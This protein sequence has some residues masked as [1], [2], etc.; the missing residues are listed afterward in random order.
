MS[1]PEVT[2]VSFG[3]G[4]VG[5]VVN[6]LR[7]LGVTARPSDDPDE[8]R[9]APRLILPGVGSFDA[10]AQRLR[11]LGLVE[12][13][14]EAVMDRGCP[15]L[16]ICL[17]MQLFAESSAEG[18]EPGLGWLAGR[19]ERIDALGD[20]RPPRVPHMGWNTLDL[21]HEKGW[22]LAGLD[23]DARFYFAHSYSL[24]C[25]D[26]GDVLT[27]TTYGCE[28]TSAVHRGNVT[29]TQFHPEKS[30]RYGMRLLENFLA[31]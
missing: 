28:F 11:R 13:L 21:H 10:A 4:N 29:G 17:G 26:P 18:C 1:P 19:V 2:I 12:A 20:D 27:T 3:A 31:R 8:V 7:R 9:S 24:V 23:G 15:I 14:K 5:S 6:M 30:H 25:A 22:L 16:G